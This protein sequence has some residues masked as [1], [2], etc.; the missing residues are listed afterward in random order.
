MF[1]SYSGVANATE[2]DPAPMCQDLS[3][4]IDS[5]PP[6]EEIKN[7]PNSNM[8]IENKIMNCK[9]PGHTIDDRQNKRQI[10][11]QDTLIFLIVNTKPKASGE[12]IQWKWSFAMR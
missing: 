4:H 2:L 11:H 5:N 7:D 10:Q 6:Y 8:I 12:A 3:L 1:S 9:S